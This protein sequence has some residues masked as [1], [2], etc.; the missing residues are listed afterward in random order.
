MARVTFELV[1]TALKFGIVLLVALVITVIP[2]GGPA[3]DGLLVILLLGFLVAIAMLGYRLYRDNRFTLD[4][5][6]SRNRLVLYGS[7][8]LAFLTFTGSQRLFD[9]GAPGV[10]AWFAL[11]A[12]CSYGVYWVY[13]Q[14]R[15]FD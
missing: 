12:L 15:T 1:S 3:L 2:G 8:G 6:A 7:I 11:L 10:L 5:L 13:T 4:T 14:S 9:V